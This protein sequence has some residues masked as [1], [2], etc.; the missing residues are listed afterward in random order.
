[1]DAELIY[2]S[3]YLRRY[4][5]AL[6]GSIVRLTADELMGAALHELGH[7]LGF[8][9]H[10]AVGKS[11]MRVETATVRRIGA[12]IN[13]GEALSAPNLSALYSLPSGAVVGYRAR[14]QA[15]W[16]V[17][18]RLFE[19]V[20]SGDMRGPYSRVGDRNARLFWRTGRGAAVAIR[21]IE[22]DLQMRRRIPLRLRPNARAL[23]LLRGIQLEPATDPRAGVRR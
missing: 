1:V 11:I 15:D 13:R 7:A 9:S 5:E 23:M 17:L 19:L 2:A 8:G 22:W 6:A 14:E 3:I 10:P 18:A 12:R 20:D 21:A 16:G 4:N